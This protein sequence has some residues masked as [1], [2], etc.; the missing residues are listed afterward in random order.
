MNGKV[1]DISRQLTF[2]DIT[3]EYDAFLAKFQPKKTDDDCF[4]PP[5]VYEVVLAWVRKE[6]GIGEDVDIIR[7][8]YP[9]GDYQRHEYP[10]GCVVVDNPP[11]SIISEI[12]H[13]YDYNNVRFFLFAPYLTNFGGD[14]KK[15]FCHIITPASVMYENGAVV[16]TSFITNLDQLL[17]RTATDLYQAIK[18]ADAINRKDGKREIPKYI[19]PPE[20]LSAAMVGS[21]CKYGVEYSLKREDA[22]FIRSL[23]S[24]RGKGKTIFGGGFLLSEKAAAEKAAAEKA[25]AEKWTLSDEELAIIKSLG[26]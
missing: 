26:V 22:F 3:P 1:Q 24:Q 4:T 7:P 5:N 17:V 10:G 19:Y 16:D 2:G 14:K 12:L 11:F 15:K 21:I 20:V 25:A 6:Y 8:F 13:F 9:G 23:Q 18:E